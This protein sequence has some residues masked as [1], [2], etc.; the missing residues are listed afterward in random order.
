[1]DKKKVYNFQKII[2][3]SA[4]IHFVFEEDLLSNLCLNIY[5]CIN[6]YINIH[7]YKYMYKYIYVGDL[8]IYTYIYIYMYFYAKRYMNIQ[9]CMCIDTF[10][11]GH[12]L[13]IVICI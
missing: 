2:N 3:P 4:A 8:H 5:I 12:I 10:V 6:T 1:V 13:Y 7:V 9:I 11:H